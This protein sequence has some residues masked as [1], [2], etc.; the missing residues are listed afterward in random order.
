MFTIFSSGCGG[1]GGVNYFV[2]VKVLH[3]IRIIIVLLDF[4]HFAVPKANTMPSS[5]CIRNTNIFR[6]RHFAFDTPSECA[7]SKY[8]YDRIL[9][10]RNLGY[11]MYIARSSTISAADGRVRLLAVSKNSKSVKHGATCN[12]G[13]TVS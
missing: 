6:K 8:N 13:K 4:A 1:G 10:L 12:T 5:L 3:S 7:I 2:I 11:S 9:N